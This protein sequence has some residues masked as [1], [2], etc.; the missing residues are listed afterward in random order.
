MLNVCPV[1]NA[2]KQKHQTTRKN[3]Y[4]PV[5]AQAL[6]KE[7]QKWIQATN[8]TSAHVPRLQFPPC[9]WRWRFPDAHV[10][11]IDLFERILFCPQTKL[12]V[13][14]LLLQ[15]SVAFSSSAGLTF[16]LNGYAYLLLNTERRFRVL[17]QLALEIAYLPRIWVLDNIMQKMY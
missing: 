15:L 3:I 2:K 7:G 12:Y 14:P 8:E 13:F 4:L 17:K 5:S 11:N 6:Y 1:K 16:Q 9:S 10:M